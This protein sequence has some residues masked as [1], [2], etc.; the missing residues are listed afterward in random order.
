M[1]PET[2][3]TFFNLTFSQVWHTFWG[4]LPFLIIS[5]VVAAVMKVYVD[6]AKVATF[7]RRYQSAG[8]LTSTTVAVATPLCS[9]GTTAVVLGMMASLMPW[10]PV[11]AFMIASPLSSPQELIYSAGLFGWR[12]AITFFVAS[13]VLGLAGGAVAHLLETKG[14]L[15]NQARFN[16]S[17]T[18]N[19]AALEAQKSEA[20]WR[21]LIKETFTVGGQLLL[22]FLTFAFIGY[23]LNNLIPS[24]WVA[25]LFGKGNVYSVPLAALLGLPL[26]FNTEVSLPLVRALLDAGM[27][28]GAALA[29]LITGAGTSVGAVVGAL[30]IAR[31]RV[32]GLVISTLL[33]GAIIFGFAYDAFLAIGIS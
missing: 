1:S 7:L 26:Y 23:G 13:I 10:A 20:N 27:S 28:Q 17:K 29:F 8:I 6:Q 16:I 31:W 14:W 9:C 2:I 21:T 24:N 18:K 32:V 11:V 22:F 15:A 3:F 19:L 30:T 25:S 5:A 33:V 12:F 4:S